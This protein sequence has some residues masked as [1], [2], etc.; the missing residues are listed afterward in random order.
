MLTERNNMN[1][2]ESQNVEDSRPTKKNISITMIFAVLLAFSF[3][4][5]GMWWFTM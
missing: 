5:L 3:I 2:T 4:A 1:N